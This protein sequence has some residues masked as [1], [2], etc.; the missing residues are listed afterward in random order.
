MP[1]SILQFK[2]QDTAAERARKLE[3]LARLFDNEI[4]AIKGK[5]TSLE[6][7]VTSLEDTN[8]PAALAD[9]QDQI[10]LKGRF[11]K[12]LEDE[13]VV[14]STAKRPAVN[15]PTWRDYNYGI[16]GGIDYPALGFD[17]DDYVEFFLQTKHAMQLN[18]IIDNH[19][20]YTLPVA[21]GVGDR[22]QMQLDMVGAGLEVDFFVP[23]GSPYT[24]EQILTGVEDGRHNYLDIAYLPGTISTTVSS[25]H[26]M[27]LTR[28][29]ATINEYGDEVYII[30]NDGH[31]WRDSH[32]SKGHEIK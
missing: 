18:S 10:N 20:H 15:A 8:V 26:V 9:L 16:P 32:G 31:Y 1:Q 11:R 17:V 28:I 3:E 7:R 19:I 27:R 21:P 30:F 14:F 5:D 25:V 13:S 23:A 4:N 22:F 12:Q 24:A 29:A 6:E 2:E